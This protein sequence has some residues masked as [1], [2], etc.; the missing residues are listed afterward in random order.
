MRQTAE[1]WA[2]HAG[3]LRGFVVGLSVAAVVGAWW[4]G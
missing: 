1:D 4:F 2:E 3:F